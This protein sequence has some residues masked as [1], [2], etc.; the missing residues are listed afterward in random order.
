MKEILY[1]R[2]MFN[3]FSDCSL[4]GCFIREHNEA[5]SLDFFWGNYYFR[6]E[7]LSFY[8][9]TLCYNSRFNLFLILSEKNI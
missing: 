7:Q 8:F 4:K 1:I 2:L 6:H 9:I 5:F 3:F